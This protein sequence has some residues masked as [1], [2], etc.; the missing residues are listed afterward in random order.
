MR[1]DRG[2]AAKAIVVEGN[3]E[4]V[5]QTL[6]PRLFVAHTNVV[7]VLGERLIEARDERRELT[8]Q[9]LTVE[10]K[11]LTHFTE[12]T[13]PKFQLGLLRS[14]GATTFER[15]QQRVSLAQY[16]VEKFDNLTRQ[17]PAVGQL[18]P[19]AW[20]L[21]VHQ[22]SLRG[23]AHPA[24]ERQVHLNP[25]LSLEYDAVHFR[26]CFTISDHVA[27][28]VRA[29]RGRRGERVDRLQHGRFP[30]PVG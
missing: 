21:A 3:D 27:C 19:R 30:R 10:Q 2:V 8:E 7:R 1:S 22:H 23:V 17:W 5:V 11:F 12:V 28:G 20:A 4:R 24:G 26:G 15:S 16:P 25:A 9:R 18:R 13:R 6:W 29:K 14:R